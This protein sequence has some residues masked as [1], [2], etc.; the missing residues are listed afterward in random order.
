M[1][2]PAQ[3]SVEKLCLTDHTSTRILVSTYCTHY[4]ISICYL[5]SFIIRSPFALNAGERAQIDP[6]VSA[7]FAGYKERT[8]CCK[9]TYN[10]DWNEEI[11][12]IERFPSLCSRVLLSLHDESLVGQNERVASCFL[13][14]AHIMDSSSCMPYCNFALEQSS[15][16]ALIK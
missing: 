14:L 10:P 7:S 12:F 3:L 2:V 15:N 8:K 16:C 6:Y 5:F 9:G 1:P 11:V 13:E 4:S